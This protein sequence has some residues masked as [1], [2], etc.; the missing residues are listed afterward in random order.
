MSFAAIEITEEAA[1][2]MAEESN[3]M[4]SMKLLEIH[5]KGINAYNKEVSY[6]A[7]DY[8][9]K[10]TLFETRTLGEAIEQAIS[11]GYHRWAEIVLMF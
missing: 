8:Y 7:V 6:Y 4:R 11:L 5:K 9:T 2:K 10:K 3:K 1:N